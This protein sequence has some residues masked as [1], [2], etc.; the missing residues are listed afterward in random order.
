MLL[1]VVALLNISAWLKNPPDSPG[2][3]FWN[4]G[5]SAALVSVLLVYLSNMIILMKKRTIKVI[6][7]LKMLVYPVMNLNILGSTVIC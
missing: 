2:Y 6:S 5:S 1:A 4:F 3:F 7:P